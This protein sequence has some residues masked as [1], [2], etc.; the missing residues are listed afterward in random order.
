MEFVMWQVRMR[1]EWNRPSKTDYYLAAIVW[2]IRSFH[3]AFG[4]R[5]R[6][7]KIKDCLLTFKP[8]EKKG[9]AL[10]LEEKE[11]KAQRSISVW[12]AI[13][14]PIAK[15]AER[16]RKLVTRRPPPPPKDT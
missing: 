11:A 14:S 13:L 7:L 2:A 8:P 6:S 1:D 10:T 12:N 15:L 9:E 16:G 4:K 3:S 5:S